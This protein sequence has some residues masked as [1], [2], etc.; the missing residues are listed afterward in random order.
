M[1]RWNSFK[2]MEMT[3]NK[4][5]EEKGEDMNRTSIFRMET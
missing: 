1:S 3:E 2:A 5:G 4:E